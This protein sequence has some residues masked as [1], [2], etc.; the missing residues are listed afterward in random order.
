MLHAMQLLLKDAHF[1]NANLLSVQ[2][3]VFLQCWYK[4]T[5]FHLLC[6]HSRS[7]NLSLGVRFDTLLCDSPST[8]CNFRECNKLCIL[9]F[10]EFTRFASAS[11][12]ADI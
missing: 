8:I 1:S 9:A 12:F 11:M 5:Q 10:Q 3:V 6:Y 7:V 2:T 4:I